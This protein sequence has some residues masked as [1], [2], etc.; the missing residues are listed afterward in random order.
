ML[1]QGICSSKMLCFYHLKNENFLMK[2]C[3]RED[4]STGGVITVCKVILNCARIKNTLKG[5]HVSE[6]LIYCY[7]LNSV[8]FKLRLTLSWKEN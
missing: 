6:I 3:G 8:I 4:D 1:K 7:Y 5:S 2:P